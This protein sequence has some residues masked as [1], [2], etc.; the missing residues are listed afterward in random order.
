[1]RWRES[2]FTSSGKQFVL[3]SILNSEI[4]K[5]TKRFWYTY[6]PVI[7]LT[8]AAKIYNL[9]N[10]GLRAEVKFALEFLVREYCIFLSHHRLLVIS[11]GMSSCW[12]CLCGSGMMVGL[13]PICDKY[14]NFCIYV[15]VVY[16]KWLYVIYLYIGLYIY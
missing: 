16:C 8:L 2:R 15:Y 11:L 7:G 10:L 1:M 13:N 12:V 3:I 14:F 9:Y 5:R 6:V 4:V